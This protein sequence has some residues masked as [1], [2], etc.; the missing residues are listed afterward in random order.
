MKKSQNSVAFHYLMFL[1]FFHSLTVSSHSFP[2]PFQ[3]NQAYLLS[4]SSAILSQVACI[5]SFLFILSSTTKIILYHIHLPSFVC[6]F[7]F[8]P[9]SVPILFANPCLYCCS[10][11]N[12]VGVSTKIIYDL[13]HLLFCNP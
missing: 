13:I 2:Y 1:V 12:C 11:I 8:A 7:S 10:S 5:L 6:I 9:L 4:Q 3:Y